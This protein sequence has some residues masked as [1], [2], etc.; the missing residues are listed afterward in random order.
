[1]VN[2][3]RGQTNES[4]S[5]SITVM[6]D[7]YGTAA[8]KTCGA[9]LACA[10]LLR[11]VHHSNGNFR[12]AGRANTRQLRAAVPRLWLLYAQRPAFCHRCYC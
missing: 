4:R 3:G 10:K 9:A 2:A 5:Y 12:D 1:M 6:A 8:G 11:L 7:M